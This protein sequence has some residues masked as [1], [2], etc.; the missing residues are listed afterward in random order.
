MALLAFNTQLPD[1]SNVYFGDSLP[2]TGNFNAGDFLI[3]SNTTSVTPGAAYPA[4]YRCVTGSTS[5]G[6]GTW[7][8]TT[9]VG[10]GTGTALTISTNVVAPTGAVHKIGA[11]LVKTIT[12]PTGWPDGGIL[13]IIPTAAYTY[14]NTGNLAAGGGGTATTGRIMQF[15]WNAGDAKWYQSY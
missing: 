14:D 7:D 13:T 11:G 4:V 3:I 10:S 6:G 12:V 8:A 2:T 15:L 5:N 9:P 1:G